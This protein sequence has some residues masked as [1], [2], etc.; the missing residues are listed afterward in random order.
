MAVAFA[1]GVLA[2][3]PLTSKVDGDIVINETKFPDK[4]L[5]DFLTKQ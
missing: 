3:L 4:V 1:A 2:V 5:R